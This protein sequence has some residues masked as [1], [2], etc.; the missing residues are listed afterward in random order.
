MADKKKEG[1]PD[2]NKDGKVT[3]ADVLKGR[4]VKGFKNGGCV[5]AGRGIRDTK[6]V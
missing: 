5:M 1:F 4:G 6:K 2:L 3:Q